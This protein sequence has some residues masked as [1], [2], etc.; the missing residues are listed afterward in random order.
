VEEDRTGEPQANHE[1][2]T[3]AQAAVRLGITEAAVRS[4]IK[5]GT[6]RTAKEGR[7]VLVLLGGGTSQANRTTNAGIP[8][9]QSA[10]IKALRD[11]IAD[12][13]Q[14][15]DEWREQARVT[16]RLLSA[17]MERIPPQLEAPQE[18]PEDGETVEE[19]L[20][21][22]GTERAR[23]EMAETTMHE[24]MDEER[25]RREEAERER[26]G[27]RRELFALRGREEVH[28]AAEEQ[29]GRGESPSAT[30]DA[31]ESSGALRG[32][33][34]GTARGSLWRRIFGR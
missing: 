6:L 10:L 11:Q 22:L 34:S 28:E 29:Q 15:R 8:G 5:R 27:L 32:R 33:G 16:D 12:L 18:P 1:R 20:E 3:V 31:Q 21:E 13:R 25:R 17:A 24:G 9:D 14:E 26:D 7:T 19:A 2:L 30:A 4:R 23:R